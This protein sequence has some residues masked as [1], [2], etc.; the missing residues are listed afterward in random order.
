[1]SWPPRAG[2]KIPTS[3]VASD[4]QPRPGTLAAT[5]PHRARLTDGVGR[6]I[7]D[8]GEEFVENADVRDKPVIMVGGNAWGGLMTTCMKP[9][10]DALFFAHVEPA[11]AIADEI[12]RFKEEKGLVDGE[13]VGVHLRYLEGKCP[14][15]AKMF[16]MPTVEKQIAAMCH[17]MYPHTAGRTRLCARQYLVENTRTYSKFDPVA[18]CASVLSCCHCSS[19][20]GIL[21]CST[22]DCVQQRA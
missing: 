6:A 18:R 10:E 1:M 17:N 9:H 21:L 3:E 12:A 20:N 14:G 4:Y 19:G 15:R 11:K 5:R 2:R 8:V 22:H 7:R 13:Y 16:Y